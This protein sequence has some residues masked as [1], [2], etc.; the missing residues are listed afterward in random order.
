VKIWKATSC[1]LAT[2][3]ASLT[4]A[5]E[6]ELSAQQE[7]I[8][9]S[10]ITELVNAYAMHRDNLDAD[11][12]ANTLAE[13]GRIFLGGDWITGRDSLREY[14]EGWN[15]DGVGM[16]IMSTSKIDV[17]DENTA[18]GVQYFTVYS[19]TPGVDSLSLVL[20][21]QD[22]KET[23]ITE[24]DFA[25]AFVDEIEKPQLVRKRVAIGY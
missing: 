4:I 3:L 18:T 5:E 14:V 22:G 2:C 21:D 20:L 12:Y 19:G 24:E 25:V 6:A 16:H 23:G 10:E 9:K 1:M 7:L 15:R 13:D 17:V 8:N 11:G